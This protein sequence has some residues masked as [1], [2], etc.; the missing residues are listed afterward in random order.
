MERLATL[1]LATLALAAGSVSCEGPS[2]SK[3]LVGLAVQ[4]PRTGFTA[5]FL[6]AVEKRA[7]GKAELA[8]MFSKGDRTAQLAQV[9]KLIGMKASVLVAAP[10]RAADAA[11]IIAAAKAKNVPLVLIGSEP[12]IEDLRSWDKVFFVGDEAS[13]AGAL[14]GEILAGSWKAR[15]SEDRDRDGRMRIAFVV[16]V[17]D[18]DAK[19]RE[20]ACLDALERS[21]IKADSA[22]EAEGWAEIAAFFARSGGSIEA[23]AAGDDESAAWAADALDAAGYPGGKAR[24]PVAGL[25]L[26]EA[27]P[28]R[29]E[30]D[31]GRLAGTVMNDART[32]GSTALDL[33]FAL[34]LERD[35]AQAGFDM[36]DGKRATVLY[37]KVLAPERR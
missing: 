24:V 20:E 16:P 2:P 17:A 9:G 35:P 21:G 1:A 10:A 33:A 26:S 12:R 13:R 6:A 11:D 4:G 3:P 5:A 34:A 22:G 28:P 18:P 37:E 8:V 19:G 27:A 31:K 14:Q 7:E 32:L 30:L 23:V 25:S 15:P 29:E 36:A